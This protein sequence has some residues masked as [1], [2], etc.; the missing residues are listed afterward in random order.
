MESERVV[1]TEMKQYAGVDLGET[2]IVVL[3]CGHFRT[4]ENLD[5]LVG[6]GDVYA[7]DDMGEYTVLKDTSTDARLVMAKMAKNT[8]PPRSS[9]TPYIRARG[10]RRPSS[11]QHRC[12]T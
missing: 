7:V 6:L 2:P 3:T 11:S 10:S 12:M 8:S 1:L 5:M 4:G 9:T